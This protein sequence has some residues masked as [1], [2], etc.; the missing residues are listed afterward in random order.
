MATKRRTL[1]RSRRPP[2]THRAIELWHICQRERDPYSAAAKELA[3]ETGCDWASMCWPTTVTRERPP[4][5]IAR[6]QALRPDWERAW[7]LRLALIAA[8][9]EVDRE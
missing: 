2:I 3:V 6:N 9:A 7:R 5:H 8:A 4:W 1:D